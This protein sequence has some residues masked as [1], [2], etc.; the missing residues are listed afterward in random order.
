[1]ENKLTFRPATPADMDRIVEIITQAKAQIKAMG[2][3][4]WQNGYPSRES[5]A[6]DMKRGYAYV[7]TSTEEHSAKVIAAYGAVVFDGEEA[8]NHLEGKW[9]TEGDYVVVHR[10]A[11]GDEFKHR[12]MATEFMRRVEGMATMKGVGAFRIDTHRK[13]SYMAGLLTKLG[14][15]LCGR[16]F[17]DGDERLAYEKRLG[18]FF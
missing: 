5:I 6:E 18:G 12:G 15:M 1:M 3:D 9:L 8:Y 13:N 2:S 14:F 17:Y 4:Q 7:I 10:L 16:V 11:V